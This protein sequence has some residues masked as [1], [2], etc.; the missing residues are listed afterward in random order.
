MFTGI[1]QSCARVHSLSHKSGLLSYTLEFAP[2]QIND[3]AIGASIAVDGCCQTVVAIDGTL[4]SFDAIA[5]TL[6]KTTLGALCLG[7]KVHIER[8]LRFGTEIGGHVLSGHVFG[9]AQLVNIIQPNDKNLIYEIACDPSWMRFILEKGFIALDGASLTVNDPRKEG[10]FSVHLI[11]ETL[12]QT[13][14]LDK[15]ISSLFNVEIDSMTQTIV[16]TVERILNCS[17]KN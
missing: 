5:E 7:Q 9:T 6:A 16:Q 1:V 10:R 14:F 2:D 15:K 17:S 13:H 12:R 11:P 3:L 4:V 8:S